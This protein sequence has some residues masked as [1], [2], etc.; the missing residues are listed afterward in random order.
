MTPHRLA[1]NGPHFFGKRLPQ[2][3][4][5]AHERI[6]ELPGIQCRKNAPKR[7]VARDAVG[8]LQKRFKPAFPACAKKGHVLEAFRAAEQ[9]QNRDHQDV[10]E[11]VQ[12]RS[13]HAGLSR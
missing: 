4:R 10:D 6:E 11:I 1:I 5:P 13:I 9:R 3:L 12:L 8:Q 2:A 7:V